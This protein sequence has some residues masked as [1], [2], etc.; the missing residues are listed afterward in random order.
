LEFAYR[1]TLE[2]LA[3]NLVAQPTLESLRA[4]KLAM[5]ALESLP[6]SVNLWKVQNDYYK[7][8]QIVYPTKLRAMKSGD[9]VSAE[10]IKI[11]AEL[12]GRLHIKIPSGDNL[13]VSS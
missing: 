6:F 11:F 7:I 12:G 10:W 2:A 5:N 1:Q 4:L 3:E 13:A 8:F 9:N